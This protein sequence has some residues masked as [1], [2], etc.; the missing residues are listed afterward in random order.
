MCCHCELYTL[1]GDSNYFTI[2]FLHFPIALSSVILSPPSGN[3]P[4]PPWLGGAPP[5]MIS[6]LP[7]PYLLTLG[8]QCA[9]WVW[10]VVLAQGCPDYCR[11]LQHCSGG[12]C[13]V[14]GWNSGCRRWTTYFWG[15]AQGQGETLDN[16]LPSSLTE[17][18]SNNNSVILSI[19]GPM[20]ILIMSPR[21]RFLW[22]SFLKNIFI[23]L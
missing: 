2:F 10:C 19:Q 15:S 7:H 11:T 8:H 13:W 17:N 20:N 21:L 3:P 18:S 9:K 4:W 12:D 1:L 14:E 16:F 6:G 23:D 5:F 22:A